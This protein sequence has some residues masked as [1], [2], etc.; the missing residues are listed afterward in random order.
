M[1]IRLLLTLFLF[2]FLGCGKKPD[3]NVLVH[4]T[5]ACQKT[6]GG[7]HSVIPQVIISEYRVSFENQLVTSKLGTRFQDCNVHDVNNWRC[8]DNDGSRIV[9]IDGKNPA[10]C[11]RTTKYCYVEVNAIRRFRLL[12]AT[13]FETGE[14]EATAICARNKYELD[15]ARVLP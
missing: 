10:Q 13:T 14:A 1:D 4:Y 7:W 6:K 8:R 15:A 5:I 12:L 3:P 2:S 9:F 11:S